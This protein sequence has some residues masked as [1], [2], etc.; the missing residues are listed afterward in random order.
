MRINVNRI[1]NTKH[2]YH[3][4]CSKMWAIK[5]HWGGL[6]RQ[7]HNP[8]DDS[9]PC[10][11]VCQ[12]EIL[13]RLEGCCSLW[14]VVSVGSVVVWVRWRCYW[15]NGWGRLSCDHL[16][17]IEGMISS[18]RWPTGGVVCLKCTDKKSR[19]RLLEMDGLCVEGAG[20]PAAMLSIPC[21]A[22]RRFPWKNF[23]PTLRSHRSL[24]LWFASPLSWPTSSQNL[25]Q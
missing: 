21:Q 2:H 19:W 6:L 25:Y 16:H 5:V 11:W 18:C 7:R 17:L 8:K 13:R 23:S 10:C 24:A 1:G 3:P 20:L 22:V 15:A 9:A 12:N 14:S 4:W